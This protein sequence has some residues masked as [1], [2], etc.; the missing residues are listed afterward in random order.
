MELN[1]CK[2]QLPSN[3]QFFSLGQSA[4]YYDELKQLGD[5]VRISIL[6]RLNDVAWDS[7]RW[8]EV[9]NE[10]VMTE[11]LLRFVTSRTVVGQF[12]R[13]AHGDAKLT[14][15]S[16]SYEPPGNPPLDFA[17]DPKSPIPSNIHV[18]IGR[19][20]VGRW[21]NWTRPR[22]HSQE[23]GGEWPE[24]GWY[25]INIRRKYTVPPPRDV[26]GKSIQ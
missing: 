21:P 2:L 26:G 4:E 9:Q 7:N 24:A 16:F 12:R 20:G 25:F 8:E 13:M 15:F 23:Q 19:N 1:E 22:S 3:D 14:P 10:E 11:S 18:L 5:S 6:R 17:V